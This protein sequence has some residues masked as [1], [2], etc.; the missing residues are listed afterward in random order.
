VYWGKGEDT[1]W[2]S[3]WDDELRQLKVDPLIQIVLCKIKLVHQESCYTYQKSQYPSQKIFNGVL[4][5]LLPGPPSAMH[6]G[7]KMGQT[8]SPNLAPIYS[9]RHPL[10]ITC[11]QPSTM[12]ISFG[13]KCSVQIG[14]SP[15]LFNVVGFESSSFDAREVKRPSTLFASHNTTS[16]R[17]FLATGALFVKGKEGESEGLLMYT[18]RSSE[19]TACCSPSAARSTAASS[20]IKLAPKVS[21][22]MSIVEVEPPFSNGWRAGP[23]NS[24][25]TFEG[26]SSSLQ[27][28]YQIM[29]ER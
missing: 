22:L 29:W 7:H 4:C 25:W 27:G 3:S 18:R 15:A 26:A 20:G 9:R 5:A 14:Q 6:I 24:R 23:S 12:A 16:N 21:G 10:H 1:P 17:R 11:P 2:T 28:A 8:L 19:L 13:G